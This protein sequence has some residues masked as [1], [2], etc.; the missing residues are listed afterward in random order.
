MISGLIEL[1]DGILRRVSLRQVKKVVCFHLILACSQDMVETLQAMKGSR[2]P[3][4]IVD[5]SEPPKVGTLGKP[6]KNVSPLV[7]RPLRK[8]NFLETLKTKTNKEKMFRWRLPLSIRVFLNF[9]IL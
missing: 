2:V 6:Q 8:G 1:C 4:R 5:E 7:A 3:Y 9:L